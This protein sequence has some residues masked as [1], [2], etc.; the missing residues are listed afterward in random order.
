MTTMELL[1]NVCSKGDRGYMRHYKRDSWATTVWL[2]ITI[3]W[4]AA[5]IP[6]IN[7]VSALGQDGE[8]SS[9]ERVTIQKNVPSEKTARSLVLVPQEQPRQLPTHLLGASVEPWLEHTL[10]DPQSIAIIRQMHLGW[11]RFP[12]GSEANY[13]HWQPGL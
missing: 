5:I 7:S 1:P 2:T 11:V 4:C 10:D 12:G 3:C 13:Y 6:L 8:A 9:S